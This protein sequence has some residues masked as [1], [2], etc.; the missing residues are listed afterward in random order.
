ML[1]LDNLTIHFG[2][3]VAV[4]G[5]SLQVKEGKT[6]GIIGPNGAGKTTILKMIAG[7]EKP[8]SGRIL[9][10]GIE[11]QG[12]RPDLICRRGITRT[13]QIPQV[14]PSMNVLENV[15]IGSFIPESGRVTQSREKALKVLD[16]LG[17]SGKKYYKCQS[18]TIADLK[19]LEIAKA[20][21]TDP[22]CILLD[23]VFAGLTR[24]ET[25]ALIYQIEK[26]LKNRG[27]TII[28][29]EH[30]MQAVVHLCDSVLVLHHGEKIAE[31]TPP[32]VM[33]DQK[34]IKSYLGEEYLC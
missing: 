12:M 2:G 14:F 7:F 10:K 16:F 1:E 30:V 31:G 23:E 22:S 19:K 5:L 27:L 18:L 15:L 26:I 24:V 6:V 4:N 25:E 8:S 34:V 33:S 28:I 11:I 21:A 9:F 17:L 32:E 13:F 3:L 29:V 20:L